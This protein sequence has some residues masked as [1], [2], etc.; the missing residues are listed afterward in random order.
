MLLS[1][2]FSPKSSHSTTQIKRDTESKVLQVAIL[3]WL[4]RQRSSAN[5]IYKQSS[6]IYHSKF[7]PHSNIPIA[8]Q[9]AR[10]SKTKHDQLSLV[11]FNAT[12]ENI[13]TIDRA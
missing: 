5:C 4:M 3:I 1:L 10:P 13:S 2:F 11:R 7:Q 9:Q 6:M 8:E 12:E